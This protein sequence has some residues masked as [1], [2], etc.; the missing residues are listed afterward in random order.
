MKIDEGMTMMMDNA[1]IRAVDSADM[2][3]LLISFPDQFDRARR[4][5]EKYETTSIL[6]FKRV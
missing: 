5:S 4:I 3:N 6:Y 1:K 2:L